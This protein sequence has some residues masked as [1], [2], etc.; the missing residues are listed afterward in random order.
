MFVS[1][2]VLW[3]KSENYICNIYNVVFNIFNIIDYKV[4]LK[5]N[6]YI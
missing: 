3:F 1:K 6:I 5:V 4:K 2:I